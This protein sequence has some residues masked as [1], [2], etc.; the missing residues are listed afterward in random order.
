VNENFALL[1]NPLMLVFNPHMFFLRVFV[2]FVLA[3]SELGQSTAPH[4]SELSTLAD[5]LA[6]EI[7]L[8]RKHAPSLKILV[9][10]F[11]NQRGTANVLGEH[12]S[13]RLSDLLT[14]RLGPEHVVAQKQFRA[15][16]LS[17]GISPFDMQ[18]HDVAFWNAKKT[19]ANL[20]VFGQLHSSATET[21]LTVQLVQASDK[22][23]LSTLSTDLTLAKETRSL[24]DKFPAWRFDPDVLVPCLV[25][26]RDAVV[27]LYK[28]A[29]VSQPK[30]IHC[31][32][33]PYT[34][35]ARN[36]HQQ[37]TV[38]FDAII[39]EQG[40]VSAATLVQGDEY[41]LATHAMSGFKDWRFEPAARDGKPVRVCVQIETTFHLY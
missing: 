39:D 17:A 22:K 2:S 5:R 38:K 8:P 19:G 15:D 37:G 7:E 32:Q 34:D 10:D 1:N 9:L 30:C 11:P 24:V 35:A 6:H 12:M 40:R 4:E 28:T 31:P 27:A 3:S 26:T 29:G 16:L 18:N 25:T 13:E 14:E 33:P 23:E 41:G 36:A 20:I 21:T